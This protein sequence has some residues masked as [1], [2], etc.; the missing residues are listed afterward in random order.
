MEFKKITYIFVQ[1]CKNCDGGNCEN[2]GKNV[3]C[4]ERMG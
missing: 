2:P 4:T 3:D 1:I